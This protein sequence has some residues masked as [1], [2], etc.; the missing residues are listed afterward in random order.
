MKIE[1]ILFHWGIQN[2]N[3]IMLCWAGLN[4]YG[5]YQVKKKEEKIYLT[6]WLKEY[7][8]DLTCHCLYMFF[9]QNF[10]IIHYCVIPILAQKI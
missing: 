6:I 3:N 7:N 9:G 2:V 10:L 8:T 5:K 4:G 1:K